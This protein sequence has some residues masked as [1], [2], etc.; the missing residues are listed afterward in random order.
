M[1]KK[2]EKKLTPQLSQ[3][4]LLPEQVQ[5]LEPEQEHFEPH[6][7]AI[8]VFSRDGGKGGGKGGL[9]VTGSI[10]ST[11]GFVAIVFGFFWVFGKFKSF[12]RGWKERERIRS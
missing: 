10:L 8:F 6:A 3:L 5:V 4:Q 9:Y 1:K 2:K 11:V 7:Q 12:K